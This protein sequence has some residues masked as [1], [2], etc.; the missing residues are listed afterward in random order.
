MKD[1]K[2]KKSHKPS[3]II[4][5]S[6]NKNNTYFSTMSTL[7]NGSATLIYEDLVS[8]YLPKRL[9]DTT[10]C[11]IVKAI[12]FTLGV[13]TTLELFFIDNLGGILPLILT[14]FGTITGTMAGIFTMGMLVPRANSKVGL[15]KSIE[16]LVL[17]CD[18]FRAQCGVV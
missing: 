16:I 10:V 17:F 12:V 15:N 3:Q 8:H 13:I 1:V 11:Y 18:I 5:F 2:N 7:L 6:L 4:T 14:I 9:K